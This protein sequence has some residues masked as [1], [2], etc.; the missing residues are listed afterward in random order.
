MLLLLLLHFYKSIGKNWRQH[1]LHVDSEHINSLKDSISYSQALRIKRISTNL[2]YSKWLN[3]C[4]EDL[5][6]SRLVSQSKLQTRAN[7]LLVL[8]YN[9]SLPNIGK[10]VRKHWNILS[11][12]KSF[13]EIFQNKPVTAFK[14]K[15]YW[16]N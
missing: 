2:Y 6:Q 14:R 7:I 4:C 16:R 3:Q 5:N 10:V 12:D 1:F 9:R 15:K 8:T 11:I 13:K